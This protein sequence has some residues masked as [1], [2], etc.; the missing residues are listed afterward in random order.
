MRK[1]RF[2]VEQ[3]IGVLKH[4]VP[5]VICTSEEETNWQDA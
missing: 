2:S 1:K 3:I 4:G 5:G